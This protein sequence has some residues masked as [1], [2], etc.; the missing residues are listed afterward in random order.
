MNVDLQAAG[1]IIAA[2][3]AILIGTGAGMGVASGLPDFRDEGGSGT[4]T[5]FFAKVGFGLKIWPIRDG[6]RRIPSGLWIFTG[7]A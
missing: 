7:T 2:V 3:D 6:S 1:R 5:Q 4:P